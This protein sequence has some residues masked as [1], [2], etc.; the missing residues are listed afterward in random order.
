VLTGAVFGN[1]LCC[2]VSTNRRTASVVSVKRN[3]EKFLLGYR[4]RTG[5]LSQNAFTRQDMA[6]FD[7]CW[8]HEK[9]CLQDFFFHPDPPEFHGST[10]NRS[11]YLN[12][13]EKVFLPCHATGAPDVL[14][15]TW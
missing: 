7:K 3:L 14:N 1:L 10:H 11:L 5:A 12:D 8:D 9:N 4:R 15:Y 13:E 6:L 2:A